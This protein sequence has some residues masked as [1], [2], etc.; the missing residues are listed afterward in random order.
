MPIAVGMEVT[1]TVLGRG[2]VIK[3]A[4]PEDGK[5]LFEFR[6]LEPERRSGSGRRK[7]VTVTH[8]RWVA[9]NSLTAVADAPAGEEDDGD[10]DLTSS[11]K[12]SP[13][14]QSPRLNKRGRSADE[15]VIVEEDMGGE[16]ARTQCKSS[17]MLLVRNPSFPN[18][19]VTDY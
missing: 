19:S 6:R 15:A 8:N 1:Q 14:R 5:V 12:N 3:P 11:E 18:M 10:A 9:A 13:R 17:W 16:A 7:M 4:R 2:K